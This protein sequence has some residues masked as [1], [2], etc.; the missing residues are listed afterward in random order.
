VIKLDLEGAELAAL[1]GAQA[2]LGRDRP[3]LII[4]LVEGHAGRYGYRPRDLVDYL[5]GLGYDRYCFVDAALEAAG[6][7]DDD[8]MRT[9]NFLFIHG[10][11]GAPAVTA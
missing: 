7:L 4:E 11:R 10:D 6:P 8:L 9:T 3:D 5:Q 1:R 2:T